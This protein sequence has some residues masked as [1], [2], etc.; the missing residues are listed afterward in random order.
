MDERLR[1]EILRRMR[2]DQEARSSAVE[3]MRSQAPGEPPSDQA[4]QAMARMRAVDEENTAWLRRLVHERGWPKRSEVGDE[5]ARAAWLLV[6]HSDLDP[7]FQRECLELLDE[8]VQAGEAS[9]RDLAYLTDRVLRAE[10]KPQR[11][12]TQFAQGPDGRLEPQALEDPE[13]VDER[14]A[15]VGLGPL[16]DYARRMR[17]AYGLRRS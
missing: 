17:E 12:G 10:G 11:Y 14:R 16:E 2:A 1:D 8:A 3:L 5:A 13:R 7:A 15:S 4:R 9:P 6:Q